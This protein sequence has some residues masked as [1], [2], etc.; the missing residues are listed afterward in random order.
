MNITDLELE[1]L[2]KFNSGKNAEAFT[3]ELAPGTYPVKLTIT[4]EG[5]LKKGEPGVT[6]AR[7]TSGAANILRYLL[8]RINESTYN[9]MVRDLAII[10]KG[11]FDI[12]NGE[13]QFAGRL[14]TIMPYR[15]IPRA[16]STKYNGQVIVEDVITDP[17]IDTVAS[18]LQLVGGE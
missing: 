17:T 15:K 14:E 2:R 6:N 11:E 8:D 5:E 4:L 10:R 9:C 18:G 16:G 3:N 1:A 13:S 12:K 7:N